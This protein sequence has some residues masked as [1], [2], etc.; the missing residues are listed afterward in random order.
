MPTELNTTIQALDMGGGIIGLVGAYALAFNMRFSR[1]GWLAFFVANIAYIAMARCLG[2]RWM[3]IQQV[4]YVGSSLFGIYRAFLARTAPTA[5]E[6]AQ[7]QAW[8]V[9]ARLA[10]VPPSYLNS[11][12]PDL[13]QLI[14]AAQRLHPEMADGAYAREQRGEP[15]GLSDRSTVLAHP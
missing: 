3:L 15:S 12:S 14:R 6:A 5:N 13:A 10:A 9:S 4:G 1:Y 7:E 8:G 11:V 2:L